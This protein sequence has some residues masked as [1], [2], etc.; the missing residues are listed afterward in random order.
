MDQPK[1]KRELQLL[2]LLSSNRY[3]TIGNICERLE[4][5]ERTF[6]RY[7][8]TF[9]SAGF[10]I[11]KNDNNVYK[12]ETNDNVSRELGELLYF[13]EEEAYTLKAAI[14]SIPT[15]NTFRQSLKKKLYAVYDYK[16][17]A[18]IA[19]DSHD[20]KVLDELNKAI[21]G[22]RQVC[23]RNYHSAHSN[24]TTDR[25]VEPYELTSTSDQVW[26]YEM[27]SRSV[28]MFKVSRIETVEVLDSEWQF[29]AEH[30]TG[31]I[32][33]FRIHSTQRFPIKL[34]LT[35][36]A[37]SLLREEYPL[38]AQYMTELSANSYLLTTDV[39]SFEGVGRF[40]LGLYN[41]IEILE[42]PELKEFVKY[43]VR[44]MG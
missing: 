42:S 33:I 29:E 15:D 44:M 38:S 18:D 32:D 31:Y 13:S 12:L 16:L 39:C 14:D 7:L 28:K 1:I 37:A 11:K 17:I 5:S 20:H 36:R 8:D 4:I 9:R 40:I 22:R 25:L 19:V 2:M 21:A 35:Q 43:R 27:A 41:D 30:A 10:V 23:L 26:C 34:R 6:Y 3:A 24:T